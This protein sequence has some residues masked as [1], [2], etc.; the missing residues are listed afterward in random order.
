M[1]TNRLLL[2]TALILALGAS[3]GYSSLNEQ[4]AA[5][6]RLM[7]LLG[8]SRGPVS[9]ELAPAAAPV[10]APIAARRAP[11]MGDVPASR[12]LA[13]LRAAPWREV[14]DASLG[15]NHRSLEEV[16]QA[17]RQQFTALLE[18]KK[19]EIQ[20]LTDTI[21]VETSEKTKIQE[22]RD[23]IQRELRQ[24]QRALEMQAQDLLVAAQQAQEREEF[25]KKNNSEAHQSVQKISAE[26]EAAQNKTAEALAQKKLLESE[27]QNIEAQMKKACQEANEIKALREQKSSLE[28]QLAS[29]KEGAQKTAE[30]Q[31]VEF[32][33]L[34]GSWDALESQLASVQQNLA[35]VK[36]QKDQSLVS[37]E[38][39]NSKLAEAES[40]RDVQADKVKQAQQQ[41]EALENTF[42]EKEK[43]LAQASEAW[44][45]VLGAYGKGA[46]QDLEY[47]QEI[48]T[49]RKQLSKAHEEKKQVAKK[50]AAAQSEKDAQEKL[51]RQ[52][53]YDM[54]ALKLQFIELNRER[55]AHLSGPNEPTLPKTP[56][57]SASNSDSVDELGRRDKKIADLELENR[58][59]LE[60]SRRLAQSR[61]STQLNL[62]NAQKELRDLQEERKITNS[63]L[64]NASGIVR[65]TRLSTSLTEK[66]PPAYGSEQ[67]LRQLTN[68][69][70]KLRELLEQASRA[71]QKSESEAFEA[72]AGKKRLA[73]QKAAQEKEIKI[74]QTAFAEEKTRSASMESDLRKRSSENEQGRREFNSLKEQYGRLEGQYTQALAEVQKSFLGRIHSLQRENDALKGDTSKEAS[75]LGGTQEFSSS[76]LPA[77]I[78]SSAERE[79]SELKTKYDALFRELLDEKA[80]NDEFLKKQTRDYEE[81]TNFLKLSAGTSRNES[82][83]TAHTPAAVGDSSSPRFPHPS[84]AGANHSSLFR[85]YQDA[86]AQID[87]S[88]ANGSFLST[89]TLSRDDS[90]APL[91]PVQASTPKP[92]RENPQGTYVAKDSK[93]PLTADPAPQ[94]QLF[95]GTYSLLEA[96]TGANRSRSSTGSS[97]VG[98][99]DSGSAAAPDAKSDG[100]HNIEVPLISVTNE[101]GDPVP[102]SNLNRTLKKN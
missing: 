22:E 58:R 47:K 42:L 55:E 50:L 74:L 62:V 19:G 7:G 64:L 3:R 80:L 5:G 102:S 98:I 89:T 90:A 14:P 8:V 88:G 2:S 48:Q 11:P 9:T 43:T 61:E 86:I 53:E 37:L 39:L 40:E 35:E 32:E 68:E 72:R 70:E 31:L 1:K 85:N 96:V 66:R 97:D 49:L 71:Q 63:S 59:L 92:M 52:M 30:Q 93:S 46:E 60:K 44:N 20:R 76:P 65:S 33:R 56:Q 16:Y 54:Q 57:K 13:A 84:A 17:Q 75:V 78:I 83:T 41:I 91:V 24:T 69:F 67:K 51:A 99:Q 10:A 6:Q 100:P 25:L 4:E 18:E 29:T 77:V 21:R 28:K 26:M 81:R 73:E 45:G 12:V 38:N 79:L 23:R 94:H 34:K 36:K 82:R 27:L 87:R 15:T 95:G 101:K